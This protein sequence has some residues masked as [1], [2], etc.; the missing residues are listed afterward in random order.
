MY[1]NISRTIFK[2]ILCNFYNRSRNIHRSQFLAALKRF[3]TDGG[4]TLR[5]SKRTLFS[6]GACYQVFSGFA[7]QRA[8]FGIA[9]C[10]LY[11]GK[12]AAFA[13]RIFS[14]INLTS[15]SVSIPTTVNWE[16]EAESSTPAS[17]NACF[18]RSSDMR[19]N[20]KWLFV[21][22]LHIILMIKISAKV[23]WCCAISQHWEKLFC[24]FVCFF[25]QFSVF[26]C[27]KGMVRVYGDES[28]TALSIRTPIPDSYN[29]NG[30]VKRR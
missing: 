7:Q 9:W 1:R 21:I 2:S 3:L 19:H 5:N 29:G 6:F 8:A 4:N 13:E 20:D 10:R 26:A 22:W 30:N 25:V 16:T 24:R 23:G 12:V 17:S 11:V 14:R 18:N 27:V 15:S 28:R